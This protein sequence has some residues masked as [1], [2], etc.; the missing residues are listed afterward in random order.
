MTFVAD[1]RNQAAEAVLNATERYVNQADDSNV[2]MTRIIGLPFCRALQA[3]ARGAYDDAVDQLLPI[4]YRTHRLGGSQS[5]DQL[6]VAPVGR[7]E[8]ARPVA[9]VVRPHD[10][11]RS[12]GC[13]FGGH[14]EP[15]IGGAGPRPCGDAV[16]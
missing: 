2:A 16:A 15:L 11:G 4:R 7:P 6:H 3:F 13:P 8:L 5:S 1:G 14:E 9:T 12:M 10:P